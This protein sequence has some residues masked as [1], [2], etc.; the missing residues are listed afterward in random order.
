MSSEEDYHFFPYRCN[1]CKRQFTLSENFKHTNNYPKCPICGKSTFIW[2]KYDTYIHYKCSSKKSGHS[3][4]VPIFCTVAK[5]KLIPKFMLPSFKR[6]RFSPNIILTTLALYFESS[7]S[8]RQ[9]K[10]FLEKCL[11]YLFLIFLFIVGLDILFLSLN[12]SLSFLF[13]NL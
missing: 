10:I 9:I 12:L 5:K 7:T 11:I 4:K 1:H 8:L 2:H 13:K 6:F 3:V